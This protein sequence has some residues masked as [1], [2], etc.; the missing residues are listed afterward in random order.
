MLILTVVSSDTHS[1]KARTVL[2]QQSQL[3]MVCEREFAAV[4]V[5][6]MPG[7]ECQCKDGLLY[8]LGRLNSQQMLENKHR[9]REKDKRKGNLDV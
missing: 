5:R 2:A 4:L 9:W 1:G 8:I 3:K 6:H 7:K